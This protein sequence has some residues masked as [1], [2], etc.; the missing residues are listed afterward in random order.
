MTRNLE[1]S[2][3]FVSKY[4]CH[5]DHRRL[6]H[7]HVKEG[8][9]LISF[10]LACYRNKTNDW[11]TE[12][13]ESTFCSLSFSLQKVIGRQMSNDEKTRRVINKSAR[14]DRRYLS[15]WFRERKDPREN[16]YQHAVATR[17]GTAH[18]KNSV[19]VRESKVTSSS[20]DVMN[21]IIQITLRLWKTSDLKKRKWGSEVE[22]KERRAHYS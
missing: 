17:T 1:D 18:R 22:K 2:I 10:T 7:K 12:L 19:R 21:D 20:Y 6:Y 3:K 13:L 9:G 8:F 15:K 16:A 14:L 4:W 5:H 11:I